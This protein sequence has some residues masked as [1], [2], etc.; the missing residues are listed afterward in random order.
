MLLL[1]FTLNGEPP[2]EPTPHITA[3]RGGMVMNVGA[4]MTR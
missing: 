3:A 4:L 1:L 2:P